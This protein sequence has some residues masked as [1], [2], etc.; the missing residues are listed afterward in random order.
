MT[1][2]AEPTKPFA[3]HP[4]LAELVT[5]LGFRRN[6]LFL[7]G[8]LVQEP[9]G[10]LSRATAVASRDGDLLA[11]DRGDV[12]EHA[13]RVPASRLL[14]DDDLAGRPEKTLVEALA[15]LNQAFFAQAVTMASRKRSAE[16][17]TADT[18][19]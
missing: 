1:P 4:R 13:G 6:P 19:G 15:D 2:P 9:G 7:T 16:P 14:D 12:H 8:L 11:Y 17:P 3:Q 10:P 18:G 5:A